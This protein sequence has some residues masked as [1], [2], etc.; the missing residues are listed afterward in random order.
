MSKKAK[1]QRDDEPTVVNISGQPSGSTKRMTKQGFGKNDNPP[2]TSKVNRR[3]ILLPRQDRWSVLAPE[4][5]EPRLPLT[6][7]YEELG[8]ETETSTGGGS[9]DPDAQ[10]AQVGRNVKGVRQK[11][12]ATSATSR[13][14]NVS[15]QPSANMIRVPRHAGAIREHLGIPQGAIYPGDGPQA[16]LEPAS[17]TDYLLH[18]EGPPAY[19]CADNGTCAGRCGGR[20]AANASWAFRQVRRAA[21]R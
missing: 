2:N 13:V 4:M 9:N 3:S 19:G 5:A 17:L 15:A 1:K 6:Q 7:P 20:C 21:A 18:P 16:G 11:A 10:A 8:D 12:M 14:E